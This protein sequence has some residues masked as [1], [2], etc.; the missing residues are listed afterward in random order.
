MDI[1]IESL[2][3]QG[4]P[5]HQ[6]ERVIAGLERH[7]AELATREGHRTPRSWS[8]DGCRLTLQAGETPEALG[9]RI[10]RQI[11]GT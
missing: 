6:V 11:H 8:H 10:A 7:M 4:V 3:L 5:P 9:A 1:H 2:D